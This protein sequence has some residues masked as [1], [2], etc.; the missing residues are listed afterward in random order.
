MDNAILNVA[1]RPHGHCYQYN[2]SY[3]KVQFARS[4][5]RRGCPSLLHA[6][7]TVSVHD[8]IRLRVAVDL[9]SSTDSTV[10]VDLGLYPSSFRDNRSGGRPVTREH[11]HVYIAWLLW[12]FPSLLIARLRAAMMVVSLTV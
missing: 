4:A 12:L 5:V 9:V 6:I 10:L 8:P 11:V 2:S 3:N 7:T 1:R